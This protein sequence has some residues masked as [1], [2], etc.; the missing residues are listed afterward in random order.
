MKVL[1][2][3]YLY[4]IVALIGCNNCFSMNPPDESSAESHNDYSKAILLIIDGANIEL[5]WKALKLD[6]EIKNIPLF[7]RAIPG[8]CSISNTQAEIERRPTM[9]LQNIQG[10]FKPKDRELYNELRTIDNYDKFEVYCIQKYVL[11]KSEKLL[12]ET[13]TSKE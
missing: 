8:Y 9:S 3:L 12:D 4:L 7:C 10:Q 6:G 11:Q 2:F 5:V 1:K 13:N